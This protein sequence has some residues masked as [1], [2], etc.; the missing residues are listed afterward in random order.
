MSGQ[1]NTIAVWKCFH[2]WLSARREAGQKTPPQEQI[3]NDAFKA[4]YRFAEGQK[5]AA[6]AVD[7][8]P[9]CGRCGTSHNMVKQPS[10][11]ECRSTH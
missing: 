5:I 6:T 11:W 9:T 10:G 8:Q 3:W 7:N 1:L 4:G 2:E